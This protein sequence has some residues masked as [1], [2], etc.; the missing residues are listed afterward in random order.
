MN[1]FIDIGN[2]SIHWRMSNGLD[3]ASPSV[4][5]R[6]NKDWS[7]SLATLKATLGD[8]RIGRIVVAS[9][10][11]DK[12][13]NAIDSWSKELFSVKPVFVN[14]QK[15]FSDVTNAYAEPDTLGIDRWLAVLAAHQIIKKEKIS[16][17]LIV[18]AGT[19]MTLDAVLEDGTHLGGNIVAGLELQQKNLLN[20]TREINTSHGEVSVWGNNTATAVANG[21]YFALLGAIRLGYKQLQSQLQESSKLRLLLTGG[22]AETL[23][24][25]FLKQNEIDYSVHTNLVL[26]GLEVYLASS[27]SR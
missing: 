13:N 16:A 3:S 19:A 2:T 6:H 10:A 12:A 14:A 7:K 24:P 4:S 26:D 23:E 9:V 21:A 15:L 8:N 1:L 18:D 22:D 20:N 27:R 11:G 17:A 25:F 5:L